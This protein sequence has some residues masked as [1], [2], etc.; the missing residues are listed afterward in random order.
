M[1]TNGELLRVKPDVQWHFMGLDRTQKTATVKVHDYSSASTPPFVDFKNKLK[2]QLNSKPDY[3]LFANPYI[4]NCFPFKDS[5]PF[6]FRDV[7]VFNN[8]VATIP[9]T[10]KEFDFIYVGEM[11]SR[12][13][14]TLINCF[15]NGALSTKNIL[16]LSK[17]YKQIADT[18]K[19]YSNIHFK[20]PVPQ[21]EVQ[22]FIHRAKFGINYI[23][24]IPPSINKHQPN[25]LNMQ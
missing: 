19:K 9:A 12:R 17:D 18:L 2:L 5:I 20:G 24:D 23:P 3:R 1:C 15:T 8:D 22:G 7:G 13:L 4:H 11:R 21:E 6:G 25:C 16:F 10:P 14:Q